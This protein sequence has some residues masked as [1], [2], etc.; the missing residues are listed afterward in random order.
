MRTIKV[1]VADDHVLM[2]DGLQVLLSRA[3]VG[4]V[5]EFSSGFAETAQRLLSWRENH[6][7]AIVIL[8]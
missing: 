7:A 2:R 3:F 5:I 8:D 6:Q 4:L 1:L